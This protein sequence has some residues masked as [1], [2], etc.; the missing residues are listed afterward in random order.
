MAELHLLV[1]LDLI[2]SSR[3]P[4]NWTSCSDKGPPQEG[5]ENKACCIIQNVSFVRSKWESI[6][7]HRHSPS[8][9]VRL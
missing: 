9:A 4:S 2:G 3:T 1:V 7:I 8:M 5:R 6:E